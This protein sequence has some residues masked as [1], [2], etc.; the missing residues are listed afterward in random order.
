MQPMSYKNNLAVDH[1]YRVQEN[2]K[3][4]LGHINFYQLLI[5]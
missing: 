3:A 5:R 4:V 1:L 2:D